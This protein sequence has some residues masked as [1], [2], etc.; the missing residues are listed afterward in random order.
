MGEAVPVVT[1]VSVAVSA[2]RVTEAGMSVGFG[3]FEARRVAVG[4]AVIVEVAEG[5]DEPAPP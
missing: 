3:V 5:I 4:E 1:K 2:S